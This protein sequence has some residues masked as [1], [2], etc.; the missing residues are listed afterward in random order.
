MKNDFKKAITP[1]LFLLAFSPL[2]YYLKSIQSILLILT[3]FLLLTIS[4]PKDFSFT[5]KNTPFIATFLV[6]SFYFLFYYSNKSLNLIGESFVL[7]IIPLFSYYLYQIEAFLK[8]KEKILFTYCLALSL[9]CLYFIVFYI[10]SIPFHHF[11]WYLGRY[12]LEYYNKIHGTYICLWIGIAILFLQY[13]VSNQ[14]N[15]S[16]YQKTIYFIMFTVLILGL[17]IYNSRNIF[18]GLV[19]IIGIQFIILKKQKRTIGSK[20]II[21]VST[22]VLLVLF[23]SQ[24]YLEDVS[25]LMNDSFANSTRYASWSC[26]VK[27]IRESY[28][29]GVDYN[30]IQDKLDQCYQPFKNPELIKFKINS[31]SQYLDFLLKG[32]IV[33]LLSFLGTLFIKIK[34]AILYKDYLYL[35]ITILFTISFITENILIRQYGIYSYVL[36]DILFL[37]AIMGN[38]NHGVDKI[39]K[40]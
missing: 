25:F 19:F 37:G 27:L 8:N 29:L 9:L 34:Y 32:G 33:L 4:N 36:C 30:L 20:N 26:S 23:L 18:I 28:L 38:K 16:I 12:N 6:L 13:Y 14:K 11:N 35:S 22:G 3:A 17:I 31:H 10:N 15:I 2:L 7:F 40:S 39:E 24:R 5:K 21:L 1:L